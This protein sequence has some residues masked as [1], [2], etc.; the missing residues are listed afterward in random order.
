VYPIL[1]ANIAREARIM[2]DEDVSRPRRD[3]RSPQ[4]GEPR[5]GEYGRGRHHANTIEGYFS[6]FKRGMKGIYQHCGHLHR[7]L[8]EFEFRYNNRIG[9]G[10]DD[11]ARAVKAITGATGKR[12]FYDKQA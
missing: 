7:Y 6:I 9:N 3:L 8:A 4:Y 5:Q 1:K 2:T 10:I 11:H 12:L